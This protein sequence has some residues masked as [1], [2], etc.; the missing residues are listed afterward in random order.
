MKAAALRQML[1][2]QMKREHTRPRVSGSATSPN[3]AETVDVSPATIAASEIREGAD[4]S[5]RGRA[6]SS[7]PTHPHVLL[8][9][10]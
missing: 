8:S 7:F 2:P 3:P 10:R 5:T 6:R 1:F 4:S 9:P